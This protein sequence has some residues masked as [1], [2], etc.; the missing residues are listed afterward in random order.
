MSMGANDD[1]SGDLSLGIEKPLRKAAHGSMGFSRSNASNM[2]FKTFRQKTMTTTIRV[3]VALSTLTVL[4]VLMASIVSNNSV[5]ATITGNNSFFRRQLITTVLNAD[6]HTTATKVIFPGVPGTLVTAYFNVPS[7]SKHEAY[8]SW[9][10]N[11]MK[12]EDYMVIF[13][14]PDLV[15]ELKRQR[16]HALDRTTFHVMDL[17]DVPVAKQYSKEFWT[18]QLEMD[19]EKEI[20][21]SYELFWIW[22][23]KT[24]FVQ[25]AIQT[26]PYGHQIF[27]WA[28]I[29]AFRT[30]EFVGKVFL[31]HTNLIHYDSMLM[32]AWKNN[33]DEIAKLA[34][35]TSNGW[36]TSRGSA[37][38]IGGFQVGY[39]HTF[40]KFHAA[41]LETFDEFVKRG[42]FAGDD[43]RILQTTCNLHYNL[44]TYITPDQTP[45]VENWWVM[46][47][48]LIN[49]GNFKYW[50]P[51]RVLML[52]STVN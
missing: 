34:L 16:S 32:T 10:R 37:Y 22:L 14:S 4:L 29:G 52:A 51:P 11:F 49:G 39:A 1:V 15:D 20:H 19:P 35:E 38:Q 5:F 13:T 21:K 23:S 6:P 45:D 3:F 42:F 50:V 7:K 36:I 46:K 28:D 40:Q 9:I 2:H 8:M 43:Q 26:N 17:H 31:R 48:V 33:V 30:S 24:W 47:Q 27:A 41:F 18:S 12:L 25:E 44:C